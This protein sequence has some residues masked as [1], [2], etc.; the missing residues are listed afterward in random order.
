MVQKLSP[1]SSS[2]KSVLKLI[3]IILAFASLILGLVNPKIGT[4]METILNKHLPK[5]VTFDANNPEHRVA[6]WMIKE[7]RRQH[8][9]LRFH[10]PEP[11]LTVPQM[12]EDQTSKLEKGQILFNRLN[13]AELLKDEL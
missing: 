12:M 8:P 1:D 2:F 7:K 6:Y 5:M 11:Y 4:K 13:L 10:L 9:T 3:V